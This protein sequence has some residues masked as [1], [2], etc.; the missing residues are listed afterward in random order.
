MQVRINIVITRLQGIPRQKYSLK[1]LKYL[2][3]S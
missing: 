3:E 2:K 1:T